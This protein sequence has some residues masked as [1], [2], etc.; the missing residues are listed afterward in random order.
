[1][2]GIIGVLDKRSG[3]L[4][5][6]LQPMVQAL[7]HRGP[8][9]SGVWID[10]SLE[11][12]FGHTR[13]SIIDLSEEGKQPMVSASG[14]YV[15]TFN[16]EVYNFAELRSDLEQCGHTFRGHSDTE[17]ML[18]AFEEWGIEK[19]VI[20]F[21][22]M[23]AF[24]VWDRAERILT[25][26]R[27]RL[28][29]KPLYYGWIGH[30]FVFTSE[31]KAVHC[32][33]DFHGKINRDV[34]A[35]YL[36]LNYIP[37]PYCI[38]QN[39]YK[40]LPG[41]L[42]TIP[43]TYTD[44]ANDFSPFP[45]ADRK[46]WKPSRYWSARA[47]AEHGCA[48]AYR[49]SETDAI[50]EVDRL[51]RAAVRHRMVA[52]VPLGAFLS[53]GVDSSTVVALMQAQSTRPVK[54]FTIGFHEK[55]FDEAQHAKAIAKHLKTDHTELYVTPHQAMTVIPRLPDLYDEPFS[56]SSQIPT[57]LISELARQHVTVSLSGDGG[58]E[59]FGGYTR[60]FLCQTILRTLFP[61]PSVL[62]N[63]LASG[64]RVFTPSQWNVWLRKMMPLLPKR[65][66]MAH[67]GDKL[68]K[69]ADLLTTAGP[70]SLY[71]G[72]V[73]HWK[74]PNSVV[75]DSF[76]LSTPL[77]DRH[78]WAEVPSFI[79]QMMYLDLVTYLPDD[80]LTKVDRASMGVSLECRSPFLD[81][82]VVEFAWQL[83]TSLK[84]RDGQ[85]KWVVRQVLHKYVPRQLIERPKI[86][87]GIPIHSWL[88]G[89]LR[90]WAECL[91]DEKRLQDE[92]F[93]DPAPIRRKWSEH[94]SGIRD[95]HYYLWDILMFQAWKERWR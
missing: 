55:E 61:F 86:G 60:Y 34:L 37:A 58:D 6:V 18:A 43:S 17:V 48:H 42:L 79:E 81:H 35:L 16:G 5:T 2:C 80:I 23:F 65:V 77:T 59:L 70:E 51:L 38:Y 10:P 90:E 11:L 8:D 57:F 33:P 3:D 95:W 54:T 7:H 27:D 52:D 30:T 46:R 84:V 19:S 75:L 26:V 63:G 94:L 53:G 31:L 64:I 66:R 44:H 40:L 13:L 76:E 28:G 88:R 89:P 14:R 4:R 25:L 87:F 68:Y 72:L 67:P 22:G 74:N 36:R 62:R 47:V 41:C 15:L 71:Y 20:R 69:F 85:G 21:G 1:M 78:E 92:G 12:G 50:D 93:F 45:E 56:D 9:A 29:K 82:R 32:H 24:G 39:L 73:S 91:L 83:P 49:G